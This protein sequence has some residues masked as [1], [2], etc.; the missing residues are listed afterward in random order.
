M[1]AGVRRAD[2]H[3]T[4]AVPVSGTPW[5]VQTAAVSRAAAATIAS[6]RRTSLWVAP[7]LASLAMLFAWGIGGSIRRPV[8][9]LVSA[10]ERIAGGDLTEAHPRGSR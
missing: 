4:I 3:D 1:I 9:A 2:A 6:F 7:A 8:A 10:A 5:V